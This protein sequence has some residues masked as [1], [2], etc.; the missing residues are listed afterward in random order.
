MIQMSYTDK[1]LT[2]E[3]LCLLEHFDSES[4]VQYGFDEVQ[5]LTCYHL[6][7]LSREENGLHYWELSREGRLVLESKRKEEAAKEEQ[8]A[9]EKA[10][11]AKRLKERHEDHAR[12]E[13]YHRSQNRVSIVAAVIGS[14]LSFVLGILAEH[15]AGIV[16]F[17]VQLFQ[18]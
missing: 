14:F 10:S 17:L 9:K 11:E 7:N 18:N 1:Q 3:E 15:H 5:C 6:L 13:R 4:P 16:G 2:E 8:E 12:E